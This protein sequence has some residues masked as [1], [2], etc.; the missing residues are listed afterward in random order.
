MYYARWKN[1]LDRLVTDTNEMEILQWLRITQIT[2]SATT[3]TPLGLS[4]REIVAIMLLRRST[5]REALRV[6]YRVDRGPVYLEIKP[7]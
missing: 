4:R 1:Y 5:V 6:A 3:V 7:C 2:V